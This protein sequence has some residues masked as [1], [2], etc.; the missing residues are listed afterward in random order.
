M[1]DKYD[2][3]LDEQVAASA[4]DA[5]EYTLDGSVN[6]T[7]GHVTVRSAVSADYRYWGGARWSG[8]SIPKG[9]TIN[10]AYIEVYVYDTG[11]D[12]ANFRMHFQDAAAPA[13]FT[14]AVNDITDRPITTNY[15]EWIEDSIAGGGAGWFGSDKSLVTPLQEIV[16]KY[17]L[18]AIALICE[19]NDDVAKYVYFYSWDFGD[20]SYGA[21]LHIEYTPPGARSRGFI[22]G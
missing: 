19:P 12:D 15:T 22:I 18:T 3:T 13:A 2:P 8:F 21:K 10:A 5:Y 7:L 1:K 14:T 16:D 4:D 9:S 20:N 11:Y 6:I 17:T